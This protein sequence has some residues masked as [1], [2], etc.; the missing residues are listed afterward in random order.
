MLLTTFKIEG[1]EKPKDTKFRISG[2]KYLTLF[3][4]FEQ[5]WPY[6]AS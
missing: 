4:E 5:E 1:L 3:P 2:D 6:Y